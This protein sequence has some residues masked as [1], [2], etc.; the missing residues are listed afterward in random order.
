MTTIT[1][2]DAMRVG[3]LILATPLAAPLTGK[4]AF[5][6]T[7]VPKALY[8]ATTGPNEDLCSYI[9][10][11]LAQA[12]AAFKTGTTTPAHLQNASEKLHL[13]ARHLQDMDLDTGFR[14]VIP[15]IDWTNAD[16]RT[17]SSLQ[18]GV[19]RIHRYAPT[20]NVDSLPQTP[21]LGKSDVA[22]AQ[23]Q[24]QALGL[25]GLLHTGA[26]K[27]YNA[28]FGLAPA[29]TAA[30][31]NPSHHLSTRPAIFDVSGSRAHIVLA[32]TPICGKKPAWCEN[33]NLLNYV[34]ATIAI[35]GFVVWCSFNPEFWAFCPFLLGR[36][37]TTALWLAAVLLPLICGL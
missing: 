37:G 8:P 26:D 9:S 21:Q 27:V 16:L 11:G 12:I 6:Q 28:S 15:T 2:R 32:S 19:S 30:V 4:M 14:K 34:I 25:C 3:G 36:V 17:S 31:F 35:G 10:D 18:D 5:A 13:L 20:F 33:V 7:A 29:A 23:V 24:A 22:S 1:R